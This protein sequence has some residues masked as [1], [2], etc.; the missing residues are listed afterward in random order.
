M[1][2]VDVTSILKPPAVHHPCTPF[3]FNYHLQLKKMAS[4]QENQHVLLTGAN[5]FV[6]SHIL[7]ILI[8]V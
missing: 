5:G 3:Q 8:E 6:A 1:E 2:C 7:A 4:S